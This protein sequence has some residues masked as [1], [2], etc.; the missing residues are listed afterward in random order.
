VAATGRQLPVLYSV[1]ARAPDETPL[2]GVVRESTDRAEETSLARAALAGAPGA[3]DEVVQ[4]Y[5]DRLYTFVL[6]LLGSPADAEEVVQDAFLKAYRALARHDPA[7]PLHLT[8]W[9]YRIALNAARNH[10]RRRAVATTP[11][12]EDPAGGPTVDATDVA[13]ERARTEA[14]ERALLEL[15]ERFRVALVLRFVEGLGSTEIAAIVGK[16]VG[17]VKSDV[18]RGL[19]LLRRR[20]SAWDDGTG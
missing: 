10:R 19:R 2:E 12:P 6:R 13:E 8:P 20:L 9:L 11:L 3:F 5:Q 1:E 18:H 15:P 4:R 7:R 14:V 17:T 16:P